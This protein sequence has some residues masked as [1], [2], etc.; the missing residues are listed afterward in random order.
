[1][2]QVDL[3]QI[4]RNEDQSRILSS[5]YMM[6]YV[7]KEFNGLVVYNK[8]REALPYRLKSWRALLLPWHAQV[9]EDLAFIISEAT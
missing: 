1:M 2:I 3:F 8:L 7:L 6:D 9:A 4:L 5:A